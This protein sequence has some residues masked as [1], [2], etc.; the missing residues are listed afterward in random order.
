[1]AGTSFAATLLLK[2]DRACVVVVQQRRKRSSAMSGVFIVG[3]VQIC[4]CR[5]MCV[6]V[7]D[8]FVVPR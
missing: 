6:F 8:E 3:R 2:D 5:L 1:M 4:C 7:A